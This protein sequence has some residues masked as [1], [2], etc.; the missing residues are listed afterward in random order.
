LTD[1]QQAEAVLSGLVAHFEFTCYCGRDHHAGDCY[2]SRQCCDSS[3]TWDYER[4]CEC[5]REWRLYGPSKWNKWQLI[6]KAHR[7]RSLFGKRHRSVDDVTPRRP[8]ER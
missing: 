1:E 5:G 3:E 8:F 6:D 2:V 4:K 7:A